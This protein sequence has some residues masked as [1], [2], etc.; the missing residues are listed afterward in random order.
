MPEVL[1][2]YKCLDSDDKN[3]I[4]KIIDETISRENVELK[5][6]AAKRERA[7]L[8]SPFVESFIGI[9]SSLVKIHEEFKKDVENLRNRVEKYP[10]CRTTVKPIIDIL[11]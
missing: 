10:K 3:F 1:Q 5:K 2:A 11:R 9:R 7:T 8:R 6:I 4:L